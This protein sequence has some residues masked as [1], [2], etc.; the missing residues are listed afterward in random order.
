[1]SCETHCCVLTR[2]EFFISDWKRSCEVGLPE[3]LCSIPAGFK[4]VG[5]VSSCAVNVITQVLG[6]ENEYNLAEPSSRVLVEGVNIQI[7][8]ECASKSNLYRALYATKLEAD[9]GTHVKEYCFDTLEECDFFPFERHEADLTDVEVELRDIEG[10]VTYTLILGTDYKLSRSG[11]ELLKDMAPGDGV[12]LVI[13]YDY[14]TATNYKIDFLSEY[15]GYKSVYFKGT[16][17][18]DGTEA[19]FDAHFNKVLFAPL[20]EFD[21][22]TGDEFFRITLTGSVEKDN[23]SW[24]NITKKEN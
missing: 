5:N 14:N 1:M 21:L 16:N 2:G 8:F 10:D 15:Q 22:I 11:V 24:Y 23:G 13:T 9:S 3:E 19:M 20:G 4:K 6:K 17:F 12:T 18:D 7:V